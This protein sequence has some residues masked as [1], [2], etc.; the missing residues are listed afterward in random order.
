MGTYDGTE[1]NLYRNGSLIATN[2]D[3]GIGP[4][5]VEAPWSV[6]SRAT[7]A[8]YFGFNFPGS[9]SEA[10]IFTNA[11]DATTILDLYNSVHRPPVITQAPVAPSPLYLGASVDFSVWADG[12]GTLSYQWYSNNVMLSGQ[13]LTNLALD[14]LT[15]A[16]SATYAVVV[17][18]AYGAVISVVS[19]VVTPT[20]SPII[21]TPAA[22][23]RWIGSPISFSPSNVVNQQFSYQWFSNSTAIPGATNTSYSAIAGSN[24]V[25]SYYLVISNTFGVSTSAV[26]TLTI[27]PAPP[28]YASTIVADNPLSYFRLDET[29]GSTAFDYAGGNDG[30]Y[31][32]G[33]A[34]G[35]PGALLQNA[36]AAVTFDGATNSYIGGIGATAINFSGTSPEFSIEAWANGAAGEADNAAVIAKGTGRFRG[37]I[38]P[39]SNSQSTS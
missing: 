11:L 7:P 8:P 3:E 18:N 32:G 27:L 17:T 24:S 12:P 15:A 1:W 28:G 38:M 9:I 19:L 35:S 34:L 36:D 21:L 4:N 2:A 29:S 14:G 26:A 30:T 5:Q 6:G 31:N 39:R 37:K 13:T 25:G 10:A 33:C 16:D 23:T 22:E 20:L